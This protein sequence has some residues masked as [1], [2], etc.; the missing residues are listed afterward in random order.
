MLA[1]LYDPLLT[2]PLTKDIEKNRK[3]AIWYYKGASFNGWGF[4]HLNLAQ[5]FLNTPSYGYPNG[6]LITA[7]ENLRLFLESPP[8]DLQKR[9]T[10]PDDAY[11]AQIQAQELLMAL[12]FKIYSQIEQDASAGKMSSPYITEALYHVYA[13]Y[14]YKN[15]SQRI[16]N[17]TTGTQQA[18]AIKYPKIEPKT[19]G[20]NKE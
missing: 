4:S 14:N 6:D 11:K 7:A 13:A 3:H 9:F 1:V 18:P 19:Q 5:I 2:L 17:H 8:T 15:I 16:C 20:L 10:R 12:A